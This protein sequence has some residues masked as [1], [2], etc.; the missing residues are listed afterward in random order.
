MRGAAKEMGLSGTTVNHVENGRMDI[1]DKLIGRFIKAYGYTFDQ[2]NDYLKGKES[3]P[4]D[5]KEECISL[6]KSMDSVKLKAI[7]GLLSNF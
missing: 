4:F 7:H 3:I 2:Y 5:Y 1:H 6:I